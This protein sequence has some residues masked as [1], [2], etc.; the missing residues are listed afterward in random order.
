M[1][2]G[3]Q[4]TSMLMTAIGVY[5]P[6]VGQNVALQ[7]TAE[8]AQYIQV[9]EGE[10]TPGRRA[11]MGTSKALFNSCLA[12]STSMISDT[13][14]ALLEHVAPIFNASLQAY[15]SNGMLSLFKQYISTISDS[16]KRYASFI[17]K[18]VT[19][20]KVDFLKEIRAEM[21]G[22][23]KAVTD[24]IVDIKRDTVIKEQIDSEILRFRKIYNEAFSISKPIY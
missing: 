9:L 18:E 20:K 24:K 1:H 11:R 21:F 3:F 17:K 4:L 7:A 10:E 22:N 15:I 13:L 14:E 23:I 16:V 2:L 12:E 6:R 8:I 5:L 19:E